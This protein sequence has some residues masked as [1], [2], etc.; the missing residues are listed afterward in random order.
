MAQGD[1]DG[2]RGWRWPR[3]VEVVA[4]EDGG[5]GPGGWRWW[6]R[7][8]EVVAQEGGGGGP[9]GWRRPRRMEVA[10]RMEAQGDGDGSRGM[11][12]EE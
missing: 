12:E 2:S 1:G 7:R 4:Q 3:R 8:M 11:E 5:S 9:G 6:P 10:R